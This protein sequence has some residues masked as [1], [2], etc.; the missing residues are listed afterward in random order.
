M[1]KEWIA[2]YKLP[3]ESFSQPK[4]TLTHRQRAE[5]RQFRCD[6][7]S[8]WG[9]EA[10][11]LAAPFLMQISLLLFIVGLGLFFY[12][13]DLLTGWV[14][15]GSSIPIVL[16]YLLAT[17]SP[18]FAPSSPFRS[19]LTP[20]WRHA[21]VFVR[22][23]LPTFR[24]V[25]IPFAIPTLDPW[26]TPPTEPDEK[27]LG[28]ALS[29]L[30]ESRHDG[31]LHAVLNALGDL[32]IGPRVTWRIYERLRHHIRAHLSIQSHHKQHG[33]L[34]RTVLQCANGEKDT[35]AGD[36]L[37]HTLLRNKAISGL[38]DRYKY[39]TTL[40]L[41]EEVLLALCARG[42]GVNDMLYD[43]PS[44]GTSTKIHTSTLRYLVE[45]AAMA[46]DG[47]NPV[48]IALRILSTWRVVFRDDPEPV[49]EPLRQILI[50]KY[51]PPVSP[52]HI[53]CIY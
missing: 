42:S 13:I 4:E 31:G 3:K 37:F 34:L 23:H 40:P 22:S 20:L 52:L 15:I 39:V 41:N 16:L 27:V 33:P 5:L 26:S 7:V 18:V 47:L 8:Y 12:P 25:T 1:G 19:V 36:S 14:T 35:A 6:G 43:L 2:A 24:D 46:K 50:E 21:L 11:L 30:A 51:R 32:S 17:V 44:D 9:L 49:V 45:C 38:L 28:S 48:S 29:W 10:I 53:P